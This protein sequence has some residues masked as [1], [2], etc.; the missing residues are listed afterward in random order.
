MREEMILC[1]LKIVWKVLGFCF[2]MQG[3]PTL[4]FKSYISVQIRVL[5]F[6]FP[7]IA[8][9][10]KGHYWFSHQRTF[11]CLLELVES[12]AHKRLC[13]TPKGNIDECPLGHVQ[14]L[15]HSFP[16]ARNTSALSS[17]DNRVS[18]NHWTYRVT[19]LSEKEDLVL[20]HRAVKQEGSSVVYLRE[21]LKQEGFS[22]MLAVLQRSTA[23][24]SKI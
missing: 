19:E 18:T 15:M 21:I 4:L 16:L 13:Q 3:F 2:W 8:N 11:T 7:G 14:K 12:L 23:K 24:T 6:Q 9:T 17:L 5:I 20:C 1:Y 10:H 22:S